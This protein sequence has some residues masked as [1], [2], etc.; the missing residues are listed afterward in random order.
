MTAS[1]WEAPAAAEGRRLKRVA[2][3]VSEHAHEW[4]FGRALRIVDAV[5]RGAAAAHAPVE[6]VL[7]TAGGMADPVPEAL[8]QLPAG[9]RHRHVRWRLLDEGESR[10]AL[11]YAGRP[12]RAAG[13]HLVPDD[14]IQH[15]LD[16]D[17]WLVAAAGL[18]AAVLPLRPVVLMLEDWMHHAICG[19]GEVDSAGLVKAV[20]LAEGV[21]VFSD[22]MR[23]EAV[24]FLGA[25]RRHVT[26]LPVPVPAFVMDR[27]PR[28]GAAASRHFVWCIDGRHPGHLAAAIRCLERYCGSQPPG[29]TCRIV[30]LCTAADGGPWLPEAVQGMADHPACQPL[31]DC[32]SPAADDPARLAVELRDAAFL[33]YPG[34]AI[35]SRF[36]LAEAARCGLPCLVADAPANR[37][38]TAALGLD[39]A[40][41]DVHDDVAMAQALRVMTEWRGRDVGG[42]EPTAWDDSAADYWAALAVHA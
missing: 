20:G 7:A 21:V 24:H 35:D 26:R 29:L 31:V 5:R 10:R 16:C 19:P 32:A 4:E 33:W 27:G 41:A 17:L 9:V 22:W 13:V 38:F 39:V 12:E 28:S 25:D 15:L 3:V 1:S 34:Q 42:V 36:M 40:W 18:S 6:I 37:E 14:G 23:D 11:A 2:V 8:R 30:P